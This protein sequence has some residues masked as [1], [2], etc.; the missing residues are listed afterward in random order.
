MN[1][2]KKWVLGR[3]KW[4]RLVAPHTTHLRNLGMDKRRADRC[5]GEKQNRYGERALHRGPI[6][7][8]RRN[9]TAN[10]N[11][12]HRH[13]ERNDDIRVDVHHAA[14]LE[15][16]KGDCR[17]ING[18]KEYELLLT[19]LRDWESGELAILGIK[20]FPGPKS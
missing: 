11:Y 7:A 4:R 15:A 16:S 14:N 3:E 10:A 18:R 17:K 19:Y 6:D 2:T 5:C 9:G 8:I 13:R 20:S 12:S 1:Y